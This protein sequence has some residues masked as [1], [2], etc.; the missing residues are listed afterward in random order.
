MLNQLSGTLLI[1]S[2]AA[3]TLA[4]P[5]QPR[6]GKCPDKFKANKDDWCSGNG[7]DRVVV[8]VSDKK[9][10]FGSRSPKELIESFAK[11]CKG[12]ACDENEWTVD[13]DFND[14]AGN[15]RSF[16][17]VKIKIV[18]QVGL[19]RDWDKTSAGILA[20]LEALNEPKEY[21][22]FDMSNNGFDMSFSES[23]IWVNN[24]PAQVSYEEL[25]KDKE[26]DSPPLVSVTLQFSREANGSAASG[27][28]KV[29]AKVGE[30]LSQVKNPALSTG[31]GLAG[32][33]C[34]T[35]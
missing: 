21:D 24:G 29:I 35:L 28:C 2:L 19:W 23:K 20:T 34:S 3:S 27:I 7:N 32:L 8:R 1:A 25:S 10:E 11:S 5:L 15:S 26:A 31:I 9:A 4:T 12:G 22:V 18:D 13:S 33:L 6:G 16:G 17:K 30:R 14:G